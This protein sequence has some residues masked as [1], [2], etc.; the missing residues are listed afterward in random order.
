M[1]AP[2]PVTED[3]LRSMPL[4]RHQEGEDKDERGRVLVVAGSVEVPGGA[5]LTALGTLRAGAG[6]VRIATCRSVAVPLALAMPEAR[7]IGL[8]ETQAG[9][10]AAEEAEPLARGAAEADAVV[11]G[12]GMIDTQAAAALTAG[13]LA[14]SADAGV[15]FVLD[16]AALRGLSAGETPRSLA[17]R[18][19]ITPHAGEMATLL[20][21][22]RKAVLADRLA[23]ARRAAA[24]F[25]AVVVMKGG[26]S[27]IATPDGSAWACDRGNV[28]LATS[29]SGDTLAGIIGGLLARGAPPVAATLWGVF[30]HGEA[31]ARLARR[32]GLVGFLARELLAEVPP[33][34]AGLA[35]PG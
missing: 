24:A 20:G 13:I 15:P 10:I 17:G 3:L 6:K 18:L 27:Y 30:L 33:I 21:M 26:C 35:P 2:V 7:V 11:L 4:P 31:G 12:P 23:A 32:Q 25:Q 16:A 28:G 29:G 34:M 8:A 9:G 19:V 22:E 14:G 5:L 1:S